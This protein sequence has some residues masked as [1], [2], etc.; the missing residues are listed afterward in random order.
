MA[1][2]SARWRAADLYLRDVDALRLELSMTDATPELR[3]RA[4]GAR[5]PYRAVLRDVRRRLLATRERV[6]QRL[7]A[8]ARRVRR[9]EPP[10]PHASEP[11]DAGWS[12]GIRTSRST[13]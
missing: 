13:S 11:P 7:A 8:H 5:E 12:K 2:L 6:G 4:G 10:A 9:D 1:C 3:A